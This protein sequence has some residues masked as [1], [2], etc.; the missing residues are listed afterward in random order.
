[1]RTCCAPV[2]P[3]QVEIVLK[4]EVVGSFDTDDPLRGHTCCIAL[5]MQASNPAGTSM[6][7]GKST[8]IANPLVK[9]SASSFTRSDAGLAQ[10]TSVDLGVGTD[11]EH[12]TTPDMG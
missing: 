5:V 4:I 10:V 3:P 9:P 1:M 12:R 6:A 7:R 2:R 11:T 8:E